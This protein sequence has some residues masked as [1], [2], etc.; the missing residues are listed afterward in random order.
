LQH[1]SLAIRYGSASENL[2]K[3][4]T[5]VALLLADDTGGST[6]EREVFA[7]FQRLKR[8]VLRRK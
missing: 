8:P 7:E 2:F 3:G 5:D 1:C 4:D 6:S